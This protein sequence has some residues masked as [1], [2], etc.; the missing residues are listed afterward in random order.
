MTKARKE[1][2]TAGCLVT[3]YFEVDGEMVLHGLFTVNKENV[4]AR[5]AGSKRAPALQLVKGHKRPWESTAR[6]AVREARE[7]TGLDVV[8]GGLLAVV[9][10]PAHEY[11]NGVPIKEVDKTT[12]LYHATPK[13]GAVPRAKTD[14]VT[15]WA[16]LEG[17]G[18]AT[19][20]R[21]MHHKKEAAAL[22]RSVRLLA[23]CGLGSLI[24]ADAAA[25]LANIA[26]PE[27]EVRDG[28]G[29]N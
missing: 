8:I 23:E 20:V 27:T 10:R 5:A 7:E 2:L 19:T 11:K 1:V 6:T 22:V 26:A 15:E 14:E 28:S 24:E 25:L 3:D 12:E 18:F 16:P 17:E 9:K 13:P 21:Q 29:N 4:R